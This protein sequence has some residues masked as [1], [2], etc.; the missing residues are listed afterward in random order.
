MKKTVPA[1]FSDEPDLLYKL[2]TQLS[3]A[4]L[5]ANR[6]VRGTTRGSLLPVST[7]AGFVSCI[8]ILLL[9]ELPRDFFNFVGGAVF[10]HCSVDCASAGGV[11]HPA[12]SRRICGDVSQGL[13]RRVFA[14]LQLR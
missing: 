2:V 9:C 7:C 5:L 11:P 10:H 13:P 12:A 14:R 6:V 1:L 4:S 8:F 3:P